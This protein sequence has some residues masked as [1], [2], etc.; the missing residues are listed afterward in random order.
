MAPVL[1]H[2]TRP[3]PEWVT[4]ELQRHTQD[5]LQVINIQFHQSHVHSSYTLEHI[6]ETCVATLAR[7]TTPL[8]GP[9]EAMN[10]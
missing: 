3:L 6:F 8:L 9:S 5:N 2:L 7:D 1:P 10:T 4:E